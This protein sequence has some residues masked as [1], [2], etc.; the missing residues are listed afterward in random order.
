MSNPDP[1]PAADPAP[2]IAAELDRQPQWLS[3]LPE[4]VPIGIVVI[5]RQGVINWC[6]AEIAQQFRYLIGELTGQRIEMLLP[7]RF[8]HNHEA[9]R[10]GYVEAPAARAMGSGR[11]L[12]GLRSDGFEFPVE[13]GLRPL[14]TS[15]GA[16]YVA[17]VVDI[18]A[19]RQAE[20]MFKRVI[21]AAPCG[22]LMVD[23]GQRI[24]MVNNFLTKLFG[25]EREELVNQPLHTLIPNRYHDRHGGHFAS[26]SRNPTARA[27]DPNIELTARRK[28]GSEFSVEIGLNPVQSDSGQFVLA[29]VVDVTARRVNEQRLKRA[30]ADLEEFG[31]VAAHDLRSPLRGVA[32]LVSW[33]AEDLGSDMPKSVAKNIERLQQRVARMDT[34]IDSL[35][36]YARAG[37]TDTMVENVDVNKWLNEL[38]EMLTPPPSM[39]L[40]IDAAVPQFRV[41][42]TALSTV[43][44][45]LISNAIKYNDKERGLIEII[46]RDTGLYHE[47]T[48]KDNGPGIPDESRER[49]FK[50]FQ[51]LAS[52]S[53]GSGIGLAVVKRIVEAHGGQISLEHRDDG[54]SGA[55]FRVLWS[56]GV[57]TEV[58]G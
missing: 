29:T 49:V 51:R 4:V 36:T 57:R 6:N 42:R 33:I 5:D 9:L 54:M 23:S 16:M 44:R 43:V 48:I 47:I 12:F 45:N 37:V 58:P 17:T 32:D 31:Y 56:S 2:S 55:V 14:Y 10:R 24:L 13:I 26:Y 25:Y 20:N 35:L 22:M 39:T 41:N 52:S 46:I 1:L 11:E 38:I 15:Q 30:N 7:E 50:L 19:R 53:D 40:K 3:A 21:E 28:D 8:R 34:L 18:S 27:M